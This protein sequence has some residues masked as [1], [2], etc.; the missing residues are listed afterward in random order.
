MILL[1]ARRCVC[2]HCTRRASELISPCNQRGR[3]PWHSR[4]IIAWN[5]KQHSG[6]F[7]CW[8]CVAQSAWNKNPTKAE[9]RNQKQQ[10]ETRIQIWHPQFSAF[11]YS[12]IF[13][14]IHEGSTGH[15]RPKVSSHT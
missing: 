1:K 11:F 15:P 3:R 6:L 12:K 14:N 5:T 9:K 4:K 2:P 10:K 7:V 8:P 13:T